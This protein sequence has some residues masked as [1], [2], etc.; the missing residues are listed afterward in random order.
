MR[1]TLRSHSSL[2]RTLSL[3]QARH[4]VPGTRDRPGSGAPACPRELH[5]SSSPSLQS[6]AI[7]FPHD[8]PSCR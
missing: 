7:E 5:P 8:A 4:L 6:S 2:T 3:S 1:R